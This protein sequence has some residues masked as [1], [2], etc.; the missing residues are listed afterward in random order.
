MQKRICTAGRQA[1]ASLQI[2]SALSCSRTL[3]QRADPNAAATHRLEIAVHEPKA[4]Q[5]G[6]SQHNLCRVEAGQLLIK[7][8][9]AQHRLLSTHAV[10]SS[11]ARILHVLPQIALSL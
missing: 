6:N 2:Q 10:V 11:Q 1:W 5:M 3:E 8:A 4:V 7:G 9:L